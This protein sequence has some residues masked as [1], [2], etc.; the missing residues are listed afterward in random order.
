MGSR[1]QLTYRLGVGIMLLNDQNEVFVGRRK[2]TAGNTWQ[3]P[4]GGIENGETPEE[5]AYRE[6]LEEIG[7]NKANIEHRIDRWLH[8]D[9][10]EKMMPR[11]WYKR[12]YKGQKQMWFLMRLIGTDKEINIHTSHPEF[13]E[14]KWV[15]ARWL[16]DHIV[17]FKRKMYE[18]VIKEF[19]GFLEVPDRN[20]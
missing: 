15:Q 7:T 18:E 20:T 5:A 14:W 13:S 6:L 17:P 11:M 19:S 9:I 10:P 16:V 8:Y 4:Q 2:D 3:M 12:K 1:V